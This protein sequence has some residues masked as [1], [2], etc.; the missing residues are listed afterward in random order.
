TKHLLYGAMAM[1]ML[2]ACVNDLDVGTSEQQETNA[3]IRIN[4]VSAGGTRA[5]SGY[6]NGDT[7][8]NNISNVKIVFYDAQ[9]NYMYQ[10]DVS[11]ADKI[12]D[13]G[14]GQAPNVEA[15]K[16]VEA[17]V[18][19]KD[20]V[21]P[22]YIMVFANPI[23][24]IIANGT[25]STYTKDYQEFVEN[26]TS[27]DYLGQNKKFSMSNSVYFN[28]ETGELMRAVPVYQNNFFV[29]GET[30]DPVT[31]Y[32]E[33]MAAK[34]T[35]NAASTET[36]EG[37]LN[38]HD[39]K[40]NVTAWGINGCAQSCYLTKRF[41]GYNYTTENNNIKGAFTWNDQSK[42]RSY[43]AIT[44]HYYLAGNNLLEN[45]NLQYPWVSDQAS[46]G[47][48]LK[49]HTYNE[50]CNTDGAYGRAIGKHMYGLENTVDKSFYT[51]TGLN[52]NAALVHAVVAG[53]YEVD[54]EPQDF[55]I[56][57]GDFYLEDDYLTAMAKL[58]AVIKKKVDDK[59]VD[60]EDSDDLS[61]IF[62][63]YHPTEALGSSK[64]VEENKVTIRLKA[65]N[66][67]E[68]ASKYV[69]QTGNN[70]AVAISSSN[71]AAINNDIKANCGLASMYNKGKAYFYVP[72][73]HLGYPTGTFT[74][75]PIGS[76]GLVRN[77]S[78]VI[79]V[80]GFADLETATLGH[81]VR[82]PEDPI[83]PPSDPDE[84]YGIKAN[85]NVLSWRIVNQNVTLGEK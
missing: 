64:G 71:R 17:N 11:D 66:L 14:A 16:T 73:K 45:G 22:S 69:Y 62:E 33:R 19:I 58:A 20:G 47:S 6:E 60:L 25:S 65:S 13:G 49:Y 84:N 81:G 57:G 9:K 8:E 50:I 63:I 36:Q 5:D 70:A 27:T 53:Y 80:D 28:Q 51:N 68:I 46:S 34:V 54:G 30:A 59:I 39:L 7:T 83:V 12:K 55:Y 32:I 15:V 56:Y 35:L 79:T 41:N 82:D 48:V 44:P 29:K 37:K 40:F 67:T 18:A 10:A 24:N 75:L 26:T 38:G 76:Y 3:K 78:Y 23:S 77:H 1:L 2:P 52:V 74:E 85:I 61:E 43:W 31:V 72:I 4:I 42:Y 21:F